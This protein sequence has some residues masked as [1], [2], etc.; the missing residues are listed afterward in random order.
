MADVTRVRINRILEDQSFEEALPQLEAFLTE[1]E[2]L[3]V[4]DI[5]SKIKT[6]LSRIDTLTEAE[7]KEGWLYKL[8]KAIFGE[9]IANAIRKFDRVGGALI[10]A[11]GHAFVTALAAYSGIGVLKKLTTTSIFIGAG[12]PGLN[13]W[14]FLFLLLIVFSIG[15]VATIKKVIQAYQHSQEQY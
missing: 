13:M 3:K 4:D 1:L 14:L 2:K 11:G 5:E 6:L 15:V 8:I 9:Q 12:T 10:E 7:I